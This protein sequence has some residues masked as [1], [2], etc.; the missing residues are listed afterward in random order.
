MSLSHKGCC[1]G[2]KNH[3]CVI[4]VVTIMNHWQQF[5]IYF[6]LL[7]YIH[8]LFQNC[9]KDLLVCNMLYYVSFIFKF[10]KEKKLLYIFLW[11]SPTVL[12]F[13]LVILISL[14]IKASITKHKILWK[15]KP[16]TVLMMDFTFSPSGAPAVRILQ[17]CLDV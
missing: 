2:V 7:Q 8:Q 17:I 15:V 10:T 4:T 9:K 12:L 5:I 11:F 1:Q 14:H 16:K 6:N 3:R 13:I